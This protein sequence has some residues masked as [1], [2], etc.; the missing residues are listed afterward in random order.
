M[1]YLDPTFWHSRYSSTH[2][3]TPSSHQ[4]LPLNQNIW[5]FKLHL[6]AWLSTGISATLRSVASFKGLDVYIQAAATINLCY[7]QMPA[8]LKGLPNFFLLKISL[9]NEG[10]HHSNGPI[11]M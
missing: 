9:A 2:L 11:G 10:I 4:R 5:E 7:G 3:F 8:V 6:L 1:Y